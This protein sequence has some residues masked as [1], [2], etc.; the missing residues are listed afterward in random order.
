MLPLA[1][2]GP[3]ADRRL[4]PRCR[5]A[6]EAAG[7][8]VAGRMQL[9]F[10]RASVA[11]QDQRRPDV[12]PGPGACGGGVSDQQRRRRKPST[13]AYFTTSMTFIT[14]SGRGLMVAYPL[15][16]PGSRSLQ[17]LEQADSANILSLNQA[18]A[19]QRRYNP[20]A[21]ISQ[22]TGMLT[23]ISGASARCVG[24]RSARCQTTAGQTNPGRLGGQR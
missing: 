1:G 19:S 3:A 23:G 8:A 5:Q 22:N 4:R 7:G 16:P 9:R 15:L 6:G 21:V 10:I 18:P 14:G 20:T 12:R 17:C 13:T 11:G 2:A 24:I